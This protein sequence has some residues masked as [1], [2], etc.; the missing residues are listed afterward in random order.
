ML[1]KLKNPYLAILSLW[2]SSMATTYIFSS[3][4]VAAFTIFLTGLLPF[5]TILLWLARSETGKNI[6]SY[7]TKWHTGIFLAWFLFAYTIYAKKWAAEFINN[8]FHVDANNLGITYTL[9]AALFTPFGILYQ[10]DVIA[11]LWNTIIAVAIIW[12][13]ILPLTLFLP[14]KMKKV[15]K[16]FGFSFIVIFLSSVFVGVAA[17]LSSKKELLVINFALWADFNSKTLCTNDWTKNAKSVLFLGGDRV[18]A[19]TPEN[20]INHRFTA[21]TCDYKRSF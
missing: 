9:L 20:P 18:L 16:I 4:V 10:D 5:I 3:G 7:F 2:I 19:Y 8:I 12:G 15:A 11:S 21:E 14:I 6:Y 17:N 13:G 1:A